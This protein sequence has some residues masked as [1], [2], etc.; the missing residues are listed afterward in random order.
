MIIIKVRIA[1]NV[2]FWNQSMICTQYTTIFNLI[3]FSFYSGE[4]KSFYE[5]YTY[6]S[7]F[8]KHD[9]KL[10]SFHVMSMF[11]LYER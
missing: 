10:V 9:S 6:K 1:K 8:R 11:P 3:F 5:L 4:V 2:F 7:F